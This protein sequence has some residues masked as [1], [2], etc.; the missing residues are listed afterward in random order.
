MKKISTNATNHQ[1]ARDLVA[2]LVIELDALI[3]LKSFGIWAVMV[4]I[5]QDAS[6]VVQER[7]LQSIYFRLT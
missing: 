1:K 6:H 3:K 5:K 4:L 7:N 2:N